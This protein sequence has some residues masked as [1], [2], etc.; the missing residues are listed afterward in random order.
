M[1]QF[2]NLAILTKKELMALLIDEKRNS[3]RRGYKAGNAL[4]HRW[5]KKNLISAR[6]QSGECTLAPMGEEEPQA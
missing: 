4:L 6:V 1:K 2:L 3:Y 5:E